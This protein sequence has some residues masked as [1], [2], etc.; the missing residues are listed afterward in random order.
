[1]PLLSVPART[2]ATFSSQFIYHIFKPAL[3]VCKF[4]LKY[5]L[6]NLCDI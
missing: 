5:I 1:M 2:L 4:F 6:L 3:W